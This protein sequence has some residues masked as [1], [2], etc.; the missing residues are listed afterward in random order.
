M[1]CKKICGCFIFEKTNILGLIMK[2]LEQL[3]KILYKRYQENSQHMF[4][5][6]D[7]CI[8][9]NDTNMDI[10]ITDKTGK[11]WNEHLFEI[12]NLSNF[13]DSDYRGGKRYFSKSSLDKELVTVDK[14]LDYTHIPLYVNKPYRVFTLKKFETIT[15]QDVENCMR[16]FASEVLGVWWCFNIK[17]FFEKE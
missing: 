11:I 8:D 1:G 6:P 12:Q 4:I 3:K 10:H 2:S 7:C 15:E 17:V 9:G 16:Y 13:K 5:S 14:F